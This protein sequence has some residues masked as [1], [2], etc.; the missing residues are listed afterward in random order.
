MDAADPARDP[1]ADREG[2]SRRVLVDGFIA[3]VGEREN[4]HGL[5][6]A[7]PVSGQSSR[8]LG[9]R[10]ADA[11]YQGNGPGP[12]IPV[13]ISSKWLCLTPC[14]GTEATGSPYRPRVPTAPA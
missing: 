13:L 5:F 11:G 6:P 10:V 12:R 4:H 8:V 7:K 3:P 9:G 1:P 2:R 14:L